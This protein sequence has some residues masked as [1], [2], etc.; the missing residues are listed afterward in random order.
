MIEVALHLRHLP[1]TGAAA[2]REEFQTHIPGPEEDVGCWI[3]RLYVGDEF[4]ANRLPSP[5]RLARFRRW[6]DE[7][8]FGLS[9]LTPILSDA[10]I[11]DQTPLFDALAHLDPTAEV[12][13]NDWG[14]MRF[15]RARHPGFRIAAG[16]LLDKGFKDPRIAGARP[17]ADVHALMSSGAFDHDEIRE[18]VNGNGVCRLERDLLPHRGETAP[19]D[20]RFGLSVY[21]PFGCF[22][23][24]RICWPASARQGF[25]PGG[26]CDR[27]CGTLSMQLKHPDFALPVFQNGNTLF[28]RYSPV[29][30]SSLWR[31]A[32]NRALRLVFQGWAMGCDEPIRGVQA[33]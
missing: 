25:V 8:R 5:D 6:A 23:S 26:P 29:M 12:V 20:D 27:I 10:G 4:C 28:Y 9:L 32:E 2:L 1:R 33:A 11:E 15:L 30:L 19:S 21:Y 16:R 3:S 31:I 22:T 7:R 18:K 24:G 17:G 13:I 14:V